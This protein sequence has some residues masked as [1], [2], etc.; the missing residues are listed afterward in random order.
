[1]GLKQYGA[2]GAN[3]T[4][5]GIP[6][7]EFG[8]TDP[9][10]SIEDIESRSTLKRGIGRTSVRID[11]LTRPKRL[12][13]NLMPD[14]S[15]VRQILAAEKSG[16]DATFSFHQNGTNETFAGFDGVLVSRGPVA[17]GGKSSASDEQFVFEFAD[18]EE[19]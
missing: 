18:S 13:I 1:M 7:D 9:P 4:V 16:I 5:F 6:I 12:T 11:P 17:R 15:Q 19:T 10:I 3:L 14:S 2:S 8:E